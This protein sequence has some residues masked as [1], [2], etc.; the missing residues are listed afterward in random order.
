MPSDT[1]FHGLFWGLLGGLMLVRAISVVQV[2]R[3]GARFT[4]DKQAIEREG[5]IAFAVRSV[6]FFFLIGVLVA[7]ALNPAWIRAMDLPIPASARWAGFVLGLLGVVI[8][9]WAQVTIGRQWSAQL[10]LT[11]GHRLVTSGPY[12]YIRHPIYAAL[13]A[14]SLS[15]ALVTAN[16]LFVGIGLLSI[17][18]SI[19]RIP[20]EERMVREGV[21]G[22]A[23]YTAQVR[24][25]LLP[26]IW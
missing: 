9:G 11:E 25:R 24:F 22:Y 16:C 1:L 19:D 3:S 26:G 8:A 21:P 10:Q 14:I 18:V 23:D 7:F 20:R 15:F 2:R 12:A 6:G 13:I 4:P 5:R 17:A